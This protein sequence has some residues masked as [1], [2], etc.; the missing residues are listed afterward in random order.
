[1]P[2]YITSALSVVVY[3]IRMLSRFRR[4]EI[5]TFFSRRGHVTDFHTDFQENLTIQLSGKKKWTFATSTAV[6]PLRGV[7]PHF[8]A[9][10]GKD[11]AEQQLKAMKVTDAEFSVRQYQHQVLRATEEGNRSQAQLPYDSNKGHRESNPQSVGGGI[12][13]PEVGVKEIVLS[14]GDVLYHPAGIWHKV[15]CIEDSISINISLIGASYAEVFC[16]GLQQVILY[17]KTIGLPIYAICLVL[18]VLR[19]QHSN[20]YFPFSF[21][22]SPFD[23]SCNCHAFTLDIFVQLLWS[24]PKWRAPVAAGSA[25]RQGVVE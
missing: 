6:A 24:N 9:N 5:E 7:T 2:V 19:V 4:G 10:Q 17:T 1:M 13:A 20:A 8:S 15:E 14:A 25:E 21:S 11:V 16:C 12:K 3:Y 23:C 18:N 22:W